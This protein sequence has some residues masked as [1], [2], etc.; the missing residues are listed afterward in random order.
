[1]TRLAHALAF[2]FLASG[3]L[4]SGFLA[5]TLFAAASDA[6]AQSFSCATNTAP[7]ERAI[8]ADDK[9]SQ[10]D[11]KMDTMYEVLS[12]TSAMGARGALQDSQRA[13]LAQRA[14]CGA[15]TVCLRTA[16][17]RRIGQLQDLLND[18]YARGPF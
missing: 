15:D 11:V 13:W 2:G 16:Y 10:L 4:A 3:F 6:R 7:D 1:M 5:S 8:C 17:Q 14:L 18:L 9:L 12:H